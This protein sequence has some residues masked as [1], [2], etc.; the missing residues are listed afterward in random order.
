MSRQRRQIEQGASS[1]HQSLGPLCRKFFMNCVQKLE[2]MAQTKSHA[3]NAS[4]AVQDCQA[5]SSDDHGTGTANVSY[6]RRIGCD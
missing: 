3:Y 4:T 2:Q 1:L 6:Q 5:D